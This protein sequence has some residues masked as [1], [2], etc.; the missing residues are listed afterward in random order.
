ML[1]AGGVYTCY[2]FGGTYATTDPS[3]Y[4]K[5]NLAATESAEAVGMQMRIGIALSQD[6]VNW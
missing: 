1:T 5:S 4:G 3:L 2:Y 6:G